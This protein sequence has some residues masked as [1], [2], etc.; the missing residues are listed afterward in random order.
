MDQFLTRLMEPLLE[1]LFPPRCE[2]CQ[3]LGRPAFCK[4]CRAEVLPLEPPYCQVCGAML[5]P[6]PAHGPTC[7]DCAGATRYFDGAR[8]VG[9]HIGAL[10]RAILNYK[11]HNARRLEDPLAGMLADRLRLETSLPHPLPV[12]ELDGIAPIP[13]HPR[14]RAWRGFDQALNLCRKV[15][16]LLEL[17]LVE[18][19]L[20]RVKPTLPQV[21]LTPQQRQEN[22]RGAFAVPAGALEG[23]NI[24]LVD[25]VYTTGATANRAAQACKQGG[26]VRVYVLTLSRPAP[27]WHPAALSLEPGDDDTA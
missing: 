17:P 13:L 20:T 24:L 8:S 7:A 25:D 23:R 4:D 2:V 22:V 21:D 26:A 3:E 19:V 16:G 5:Q 11:F 15:S 10:R 14:R 18:G 27:P 12:S 1:L 9:L 6:S